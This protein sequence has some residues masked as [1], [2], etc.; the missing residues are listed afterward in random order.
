MRTS[1]T[2]RLVSTLAIALA[3]GAAACSGTT[4][5]GS[6]TQSSGTQ[7]GGTGA[8][9]GTGGGTTGTAAKTDADGDGYFAEDNDCDDGNPNIHPGATEVCNNGIDD[10][11]DG[12]VDESIDKDGDGFGACSGDCND[13]DSA[14]NPSANEVPGDGIDNNCDGIVDD[15]FD[16]DG[17]TTAMGDCDDNNKNI[18][19]GA[20]EQCFN[21]IDDNCNGFA[22]A[23]EPDADGDGFGPCGGDCDDTNPNVYPGAPEIAGDGLDNNCDNLVDLDVDGD[24]W[25]TTNGDCDDGNAGVNPSA[26]EICNNG[27]DD[28][29]NGTVDTDCLT[30]CDLANLFASSVG[31]LY[32]AVDA[33]NDPYESYD[34]LPFAVAVSNT[35]PTTTAT[36]NVQTRSGNVWNTIQTSTV[37]P[38]TLKQFNLPDRHINY[39]GLNS[40]GAYRIV[41]DLPIIAYQF[42]PID[43]VN[44]YTSDASLLLPASALDQFYYVANWGKPS[45][46]NPQLV[47]AA[48]Q[49]GTQVTIRST[50]PV[51]AGGA[52]AAISAG[53]NYTFPQ[54]LNEGDYIQ[55]EGVPLGAPNPQSFTGT[56]IT[57]TKPISV[58]SN[59]WCGNV[60]TQV[61]CCDHL[62]EQIIGLQTWGKNYV[63][64]RMPVRS[65]GTPD[66]TVWQVLASQD[67]TTVTFNAAAGVTGLPNGPQVL[68]AGQSIQLSVTGTSANPGDFLVNAD[69]PIFLM[70]YLTSS[71]TTNAPVNLAGDPAMT[72]AV[73]VEQFLDSYVVL[74]PVNWTYDYFILTK[75]V[76][77]TITIDGAQV[78]QNN[79]VGVGNPIQWEAGRV[80]VPDGVHVVKG[81]APFGVVVVGYDAY[82]SYAYPGGLNQKI[83]NPLN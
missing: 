28:N 80:A 12:T 18:Y 17:F 70:E 35:D 9:G 60:P 48:A 41:S 39:T 73:P 47:I 82:D 78:G 45:F 32:Y 66:A 19:P 69:K 13:N 44:S 31:C 43:G 7:S 57:S 15:D 8:A 6:G 63:A 74:V 58:F 40:A 22:D 72:Q 79:F 61:C 38:N 77:A 49:D 55:L 56:Y 62:E 68:N 23:A 37:A 11:C 59:N 64:S 16:A 53:V 51:Q 3:A 36:V 83:L 2:L 54:T 29:C 46:G 42:Q 71:Q 81:S 76:G 5:T 52:I 26:N 75:P 50:I 20:K 21:G 4:E 14:V 33:N 30:P 27:V 65:S 1:S 25:T 67:Q 34:T 24:G 10:N